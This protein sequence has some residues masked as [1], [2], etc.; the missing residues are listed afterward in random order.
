MFAGSKPAQ[1]CRWVWKDSEVSWLGVCTGQA[2]HQTFWE[3]LTLGLALCVW[4][5]SFTATAALLN[6][7]VA[8]LQSAMD[9]KGKGA[10]LAVARELSW[11]KA[12]YGWAFE[13][14]HLPTEQHKLADSLSRMCGPDPQDLPLE[15]SEAHCIDAYPVKEFWKL[16]M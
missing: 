1:Y 14:G 4:G 16:R 13:V 9:L 3:L 6:D 8:A 15:L 10:L 2:K 5:K 12:K 7:N 11:R